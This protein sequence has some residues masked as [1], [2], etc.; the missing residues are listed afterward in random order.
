M[1]AGK[2]FNVIQQHKKEDVVENEMVDLP[3]LMEPEEGKREEIEQAASESR[4]L[5]TSS[6]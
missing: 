4:R 3:P 6:S 2:R 5:A 1:E